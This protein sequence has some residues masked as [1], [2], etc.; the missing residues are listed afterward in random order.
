MESRPNGKPRAGRGGKNA[1]RGQGSNR[2]TDAGP[3]NRDGRDMKEIG[4]G[5]TRNRRSVWTVCTKPFKGAH[6]ATFPP[7]LIEPCVLAGCPVGGTVF[8]PFNGAGTTGVVAKQHGRNYV[9]IELNPA[10]VAMAEA[11]I[12]AA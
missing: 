7:K 1:F 11:R 9:G 4:T 5:A 3:A 12:G 10:Y 2:D 8:D 6:F